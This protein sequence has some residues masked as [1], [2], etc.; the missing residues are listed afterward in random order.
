MEQNNLYT[1]YRAG[2]LF[3]S[4]LIAV[5][6]THLDVYK[7]QIIGDPNTVLLIGEEDGTY[8]YRAFP[9]M[10]V[11]IDGKMFFW[12]DEE[13]STTDTIIN[14]LYRHNFVDTMIVNAYI[15]DRII[16]D[17]KRGV[18]YYFCKND[19]INYKKTGSN[20]LTKSYKPPRLRCKK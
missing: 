1:P 11:E 13:K 20:T 3:I 10:L 12:Y 18:V 15:P 14:T 4:S 6:Y 17:A 7:R 9:T 19:L 8:D 5:S 2:F 16:N